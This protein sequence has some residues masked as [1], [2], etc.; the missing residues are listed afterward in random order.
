M[1]C[2][3]QFD[4]SSGSLRRGITSGAGMIRKVDSR[5][6]LRDTFLGLL[7]SGY[8]QAGLGNALFAG[9]V[10]IFV[11]TQGNAEWEEG[12]VNAFLSIEIRV[13]V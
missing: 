13:F 7:G 6:C 3:H 4:P 9:G 5:L 12:A 11:E 8:L 2:G 10:L 1:A